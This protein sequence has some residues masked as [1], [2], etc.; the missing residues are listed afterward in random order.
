MSFRKLMDELANKENDKFKKLE[1]LSYLKKSN[2]NMQAE[3]AVKQNK[4]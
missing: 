4:L 2:D 1:E 3:I